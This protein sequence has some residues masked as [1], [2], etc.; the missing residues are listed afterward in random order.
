MRRG[1]WSL[2]IAAPLVLLLAIGFSH[3]PNA[4][5]SSLLNKPAPAFALTSA[6]GKV[7]SL[8]DYRGRPVVLNFWATWCPACLTEHANLV[9]LYRR[10]APKGVAFLGISFH[11]SAA[12][13]RA[14]LRRHGGSWPILADPGVRTA[15]A[16]GVAGP[17]ETFLV[18][19]S[20]IIRFKA[21]GAV[22]A[23]GA[24]APGAFAAQ[25]DKVLRK[26]A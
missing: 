21:A 9:R 13:G 1:L 10:Y 6:Q 16:Y 22:A 7:V 17:P 3:D 4:S 8:A 20:G 18:D 26:R 11:D 24:V 5:T 15:I 14:F 12:A 23:G 2:P 25:I 19:G